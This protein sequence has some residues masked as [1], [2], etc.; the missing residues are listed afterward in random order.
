MTSRR[1]FPALF[2]NELEKIWAHRGRVLIIAFIL[3]VFGGSFI[4]YRNYEGTQK[5][6]RSEISSAESQVSQ[7]KGQLAHAQGSQKKALQAQL[8]VPETILQQAHQNSLGTIQVRPQMANLKQSIKTAP[9]PFKGNSEEQLA[10]DQYRLQHGIT[11]YQPTSHGG[12][13]L[14]GQVFSGLTMILMALVALAISADRVSSE[15]EAGT[16]GGLL[17][18]APKRRPVY[19]AKLSASLIVI[20]SFMVAAAVGFFVVAGL[21]MGF[22]S[23]DNPH[24]VSLKVSTVGQPA[25]GQLVIPVQHFHMLPQ[26]SYDLLS[27][28]LAMLAIGALVS[29]FLALSMVTRSTVFSLIVGAVLVL[30]DVL[31]HAVGSL[32]L[33]DPAI[34]LPLMSE[35]TRSLA[36]QYNMASLS[37]QTGLAVLLGWTTVSILF[38]LW[39]SKRLDL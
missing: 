32:A 1:L 11:Q 8:Q 37:L 36:M 39:F 27:L 16:W 33:I 5:A 29:I 6:Y 15:F 24:V 7:I 12:Y 13:R 2:H 10:M 14:V 20:W 38:S 21:L 22:G 4:A 25:P 31:A 3:L 9:A 23:P 34:H 18:H 28:G 26:W 30:S 35:W 19:L 17:L